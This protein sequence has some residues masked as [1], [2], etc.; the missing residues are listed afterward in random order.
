MKTL[1]SGE[2]LNTKAAA[3]QIGI[4]LRALYR[5]I[6]EGQLVAYKI[7]RVIRLKQKD[8]DSYLESAQIEPGTLKHLY[9]ESTVPTE[10]VP[11]EPNI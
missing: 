9:P 4:T 10:P 5:L 1:K 6:D 7:G 8:V 2:W 3:G 11:I